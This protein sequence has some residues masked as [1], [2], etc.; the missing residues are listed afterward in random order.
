M[1]MHICLC[2]KFCNRKEIIMEKRK[3]LTITL[4]E[5]CNLSC[6]YCYENHKSLR[7]MSIDTLKKIIKNEMCNNDDFS[8]VEI[9]LFGGEPFIKF[10]L[11]KE[12]YEYIKN[13]S[14]NKKYI[15]FASTNGTLVHGEIKEWL[16]KSPYFV[17]G[18]SYDGTPDM[19]NIN[20]SNSAN[21][22]DLSFFKEQYPNQPV[23]MTISKETLPY[24]S[25]GVIFLQR[26]GFDVS[27][28]LAYGIDWSDNTNKEIL[29]NE[30]MKLVEF[31]L[32]N[33][34]LKPCSM[35][36][37]SISN[38]ANTYSSKKYMRYCGAGIS[39]KAYDVNGVE[40]PCQFF[41]PLSV[42]EEKARESLNLTFYDK[43]I[44][45]KNIEEKC[46]D[47]I[48]QSI[49]PTCYGSNY[50]STGSIYIHDNNMCALNKI[51]LKA[52]S[53]FKAMQWKLGQLNLSKR[54]EIN[55]LKSIKLI[56]E[57]I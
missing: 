37:M 33:P 47:C 22:I 48:V 8:E 3:Y 6:T 44:P 34:E 21:K 20:R 29:E 16:K 39:T 14:S 28:N 1:E 9:G 57:N 45:E 42:G 10:N 41:M 53:Y 50:A 18:L 35:L 25:E 7:C 26:K 49:C 5:S 56:Q 32:N 36:D 51:Q 31:Y 23:K 24:L 11:I 38:I 46:R 43:S 17:C 52:R 12:I 19:T 40:Y 4:T 15:F 54:E 13:L 27:C 30:L 55:L 2:S